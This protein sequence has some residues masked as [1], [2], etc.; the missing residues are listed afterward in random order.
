MKTGDWL[1]CT[2]A[3]GLIGMALAYLFKDTAIALWMLP[4]TAYMLWRSWADDRP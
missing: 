1:F 4:W 2:Y 3:A